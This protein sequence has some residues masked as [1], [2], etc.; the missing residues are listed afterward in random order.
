MTAPIRVLLA[1][2]SETLRR[3]VKAVIRSEPSILLVGEVCNYQELLAALN[4]VQADV[5][6]MDV[7]MP[8]SEHVAP[9]SIKAQLSTQCLLA[10]SF[11][12]DE[13]TANHAKNYGAVRLL[14]KIELARTLIPAMKDCLQQKGESQS[15]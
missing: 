2:D 15:A 11:A 7:H 6:V 12:N 10:I 4:R 8:D 5:V 9:E 1:D 13:E 3:A 14:D